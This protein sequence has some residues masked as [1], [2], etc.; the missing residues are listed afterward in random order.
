MGRLKKENAVK[1]GEL[2]KGLKRFSFIADVQVIQFFKLLSKR[3]KLTLKDLMH[4]ALTNYLKGDIEWE[5]FR[6]PPVSKN[7]RLLAE[8]LNKKTLQ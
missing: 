7:E 2:Q 8:Y 4:E 6:S 1:R 5:L 3:K